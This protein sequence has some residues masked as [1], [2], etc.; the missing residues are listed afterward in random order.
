MTEKLTPGRVEELFVDCF[1][2]DGEKEDNPIIAEGIV[3]T[4]GF[5]PTRLESH[6]QEVK[7]LLAQ[8]PAEFHEGTGDG[9]SFLNA[10]LDREG[11][12]WTGEHR[13]MEHLFVL[14]IALGLVENLLPRD[15]W[16]VLPGGMPY[17]MIVNCLPLPEGA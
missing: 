6:R 16:S 15:M 12:Q 3:A 7:D 11:N 8:L 14:G 10:C 17:Y 5:Q 1:F 2:K 4:Y 13:I 9:W